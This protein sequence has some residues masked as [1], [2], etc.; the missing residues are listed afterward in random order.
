M[1]AVV[2]VFPVMTETK[3]ENNE[4]KQQQ[5]QKLLGRLSVLVSG[6]VVDSKQWYISASR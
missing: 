5:L 1:A 3:Q 6:N 2:S 4:S